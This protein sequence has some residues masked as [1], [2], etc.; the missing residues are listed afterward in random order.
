MHPGNA[1]RIGRNMQG[2]RRTLGGGLTFGAMTILVACLGRGDSRQSLVAE[3]AN[4][5]PAIV[6]MA[7]S[8]GIELTA[9]AIGNVVSVTVINHS[10][11]PILIGPKYFAVIAEG[12]LHPVDP[13]NV[14]IQFPI[15]TIGREEGVSG[16]FQFRGLRSLEGQKLVLKSPDAEQMYVVINRYGASRPSSETTAT[17]PSTRESRRSQRQIEKAQRALLEELTKRQSQ[18][19]AK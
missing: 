19:P 8:S 4:P 5:Q 7:A 15:R 9:E 14:T 12:K 6:P 11:K 13:R 18:P 17:P 16:A 2:L 3:L 1:R 10:N